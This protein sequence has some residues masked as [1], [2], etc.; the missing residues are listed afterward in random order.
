[1]DLESFSLLTVV[2]K[3]SYA[4]VVLVRKKDNDKIY[5]MKILKK[6]YIEKKK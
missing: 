6:A 4:K 2:G 3:G 1:V 5:A